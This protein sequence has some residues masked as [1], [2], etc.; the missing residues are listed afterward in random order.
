V[1]LQ[2][3]LDRLGRRLKRWRVARSFLRWLSLT[4]GLWLLWF[5]L[6]NL[7]RLPAGIRLAMLG[8]GLAVPVWRALQE[9][10]RPACRPVSPARTAREI[11]NRCG[12]RDNTLINACCFEQ[13]PPEGA[14]GAFAW[15]ARKVGLAC[16]ANIHPEQLFDRRALRRAGAVAS[17][18]LLIWGAYVLLL[19]RHA[20]NAFARLI[21]PLADIPP[22]TSV[23]VSL[24]PSRTVTL[25]AGDSLVVTA[26]LRA[27]TGR[28]ESFNESPVLR[29]TQREG[30][31]EASVDLP[32]AA[33]PGAPGCHVR[34][35]EAVREPFTCNA[36]FG[37]T[38]SRT[39]TVQVRH[40]P[41]ITASAFEL[42]PPSYAGTGT[43]MQAGAPMPLRVLA[44]SRARVSV[45]LDRAPQCLL[46]RQGGAQ[47]ALAQAG[48]G[49]WQA[50]VA[51]EQGGDYLL[52]AGG[53]SEAETRPVARGEVVLLP[54]RT[55]EVALVAAS[56]NQRVW[57]GAKLALPVEAGD[58]FG[59]QAVWVTAAPVAAPPERAEVL[60]RWPYAGP[61]GRQGSV[62][63]RLELTLDPARFRPGESYRLE[64]RARDWNPD[65][66]VAVSAPLVIRIRQPEEAAEQL[67]GAAQEAAR[68][69]EQAVAEQRRA[70]GL[71][72]NLEVHL[73]EALSRRHIGAHRESIAK[74]QES[75]RKH[76]RSAVAALEKAA[77]PEATRARLSLLV[78]QEM[79]LAL[80][81]ITA[82]EP[83]AE[84]SAAMQPRVARLAGHQNYILNEL[85]SLLGRLAAQARLA[86]ERDGGA[87]APPMATDA[88]RARD[89]Q[90][91]LKDFAA[92][93]KRI[94]EQT[95]SLLERGPEDL[96]EEELE[97][98]GQL[99]REEGKWAALLRDRLDDLAKNP[100]QDF[101]DG[102]MAEAFN[103]VWQDVQKAAESLYARKIEMAV[104][105]EQGGLENAEELIHNLERWLT[106]K[107]DYIKWLMEEPPTL[108]DAPLAELPRELEDIA[109]EL[110]DE[111][112]AMT[113]DVEDVT[114]G[115]IDSLDKGAGWDAMDGPISSMGAKG[116]TGNQLPNQHEIGGRSGE[117][118]TGRSQG[119]MVEGTAVGKEG[120]Q[121]PSR[122]TPTPF[123]TGAVDDQSTASP[124]GAT[125]GGKLAGFAEQGLRGP[126]PPPRRE[127]MKRLAGRQTEIRQQAERLNLHLRAHG[128]PSGDLDAAIANM[129]ELERHAIE[130]RGAEIR[131]AFD[132]TLESMRSTR[133]TIAAEAA[134]RRERGALPRDKAEAL[135]SGLRADVPPGY[136]EI[137]AAYYRRLA[138][139]GEG[140][141]SETRE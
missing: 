124:G 134:T 16:A 133:A 51:L 81:R 104:P 9:W 141:R 33:V 4:L 98:L 112:S 140:G 88:D 115:W 60:A 62:R 87:T 32:M 89:L 123:E 34:R 44:G 83:P 69:L 58:D 41:R 18:G 29:Q 73:D 8:V 129:R 78:E 135:W 35:F 117:G 102:S 39:L 118:R 40:P 80:E 113:E 127:Q 128:V 15:R 86:Q 116:V 2:L 71:T 66:T 30:L 107:P 136:E 48:T 137:V 130:G 75:A 139:A 61:P 101:A 122:V 93:Q 37:D 121:T 111:E 45:T 6:D 1:T 50:E 74:A 110:L 28:L 17:V 114:S 24:S 126:A 27:V 120:R 108:P 97:I 14:A 53:G 42:I 3:Q 106:D 119:Q 25:W 54:D 131:R 67:E 79:G 52:M 109:G 100:L 138:G 20:G 92:V 43:T 64:A 12:I 47:H 13:T 96:T 91:F 59:L 57:S 23:T 5:W 77:A 84:T 36:Q 56:R 46:W 125:G 85:L 82:L 63:E 90:E 99:A 38:W 19:S 94:V 26:Q 21:M 72:R 65:G 68:A 95:R 49:E 10:L 31:R 103:E 105:Q 7:L 22:V 11:E 76:G 70:L 55:P 132:A